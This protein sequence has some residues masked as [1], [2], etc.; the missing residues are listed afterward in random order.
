MKFSK[1]EDTRHTLSV[2]L[3]PSY[4]R[5]THEKKKEEP[6]PKENTEKKSNKKTTIKRYIEGCN[7]IF[8]EETKKIL[9]R[10][11]RLQLFFFFSCFLFNYVNV[12]DGYNNFIHYF[13]I[14]HEQ[15]LI[16]VK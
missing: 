11:S 12:L 1:M 4:K 2:A 14:N 7:R 9:I 15:N 16:V 8:K 13:I 10:Q 3:I 5:S 6:S